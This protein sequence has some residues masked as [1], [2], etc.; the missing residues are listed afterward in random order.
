[1]I[2]LNFVLWTFLLYWLHRLAHANQFLWKFHSDHH[3]QVSQEKNKGQHWANYFLF[4][5]TWKSTADQWLIEILPTILLCFILNDFSLFVFYWFWAVF[6]QERIRHN[7]NFNLY[8]FL[9]SGKWHLVHHQFYN[10]NFGVF[11]AVWDLVF[12]T[13]KTILKV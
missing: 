3:V 8:P 4:F 1:M 12:Q 5:D 13:H 2:L 11:T 7:K 6:I 9:T 10:R